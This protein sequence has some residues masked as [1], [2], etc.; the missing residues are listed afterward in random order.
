M[1][2]FTSLRAVPHRKPPRG[3][4]D[5]RRAR[6]DGRDGEGSRARQTNR[7]RAIAQ[8]RS[9]GASPAHGV[10]GR[11]QL[12][13]I[14]AFIGALHVLG[15][16]TLLAIVAPQHL[17]AGT[18]SGA[19]IGVAAYVF[20]LRHAFDADHIAAIDNTTRRLMS[21]GE[22]P[23]SVGF[24]FSL[25]HSTIVFGVTLLIA[26]G[27]RSL[28]H[29]L[30]DDSSL[31]GTLAAVGTAVS[32]GFLLLV[33]LMNAGAFAGLWRALARARGD[34]RDASEPGGHAATGGLVTR[35]VRRVGSPVEKPWHM[36]VVGAMFGLGF[37][38]ATE[39]ALL[40]AAG[41]GSASGLPW[42]AVMCLP[43]LFAAGMSLIDTLDGTFMSSVYGRS[44]SEPVRR[45]QYS[46]L[47]TG[48]SI[49]I[50]VG[51][52]VVELVGLLHDRL[53]LGSGLM[54]SVSGLDL[55]TV[56]LGIV[57]LFLLTWGAAAFLWRHKGLDPGAETVPRPDEAVVTA[58][59]GGR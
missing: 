30:L 18:L 41:T 54:A 50:A 43:V 19:G 56:G 7:G 36:Y 59:L 25:G 6:A 17:K 53:H 44:L 12:Y 28:P 38:T 16:G 9:A 3:T 24:W 42:Y 1:I 10:G 11:R 40:V 39:I 33:A 47:V 37:D 4:G 5:P 55:N 13:A 58:P 46:L 21:R 2:V 51:V 8:I 32:G 22:R 31:G 15:W 26:L 20:G 48:L 45:I 57:V 49:A 52:G 29:R 14:A 34:D 23:R 27:A 35:V